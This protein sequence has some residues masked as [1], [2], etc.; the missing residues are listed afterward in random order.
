[1]IIKDI[2]LKKQEFLKTYFPSIKDKINLKD[3]KLNI[4][5]KN[6]KLLF[7]GTGK[8]KID[9]EFEKIDYFISKKEKKF[10]FEIGLDLDKTNFKIDN[11]NYQKKN[12]V[13]TQLKIKGN[14]EENKNLNLINIDILENDNK[15]KINNLILGKNNLIKQVDKAEFDYLD[16]ENK[17]NQFL[18]QR[19]EK[20]IYELNGIT[21][22]ANSLITNLLKSNDEKVDQIFENNISLNLNLDEI[23]ID[24]TYIVRNLKGRLF[25]NDNKVSDANISAIFKNKENLL[26]MINTDNE[27][28]KITTL[29]S[30]WAKPLV[31]RYKFIKGFEEGYLDFYS[32][33]KDGVSNS[34]LVI[35]NFKIKEIP[36]LAKLLSLA[37]LQG[38]AD[39]LTGEGIRFT[40]FEMKFSNNKKLMNID[41]LYAIG[42]SISLLM[43]GYVQSDELISLRGTLV[44]SLN[45]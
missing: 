16:K 9:N 24:K 23:Y 10:D 43:E 14:F 38:I 31:N 4:N 30:S 39:L 1:M 17:K 12:K 36:V 29:T 20:N 32:S 40:D 42:P 15:I 13:N 35:D 8:I 6:K 44:P 33:K 34:V 5:Y 45:N 41:E 22:N 37:S 3:H 7:S 27:G 25:I 11:L 2:N 19:K 21:Y 26:L 18:I 28:K